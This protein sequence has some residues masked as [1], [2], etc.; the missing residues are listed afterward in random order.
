MSGDGRTQVRNGLEAHLPRLWRY[1]F[2]LT[3]RSQDAED[4]A[5]ATC[6]RAIERAHQ[7]VPGTR[8]DRWL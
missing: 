6:L 5:Q 8:L 4:L 7:F 1:A 3:R 2:V